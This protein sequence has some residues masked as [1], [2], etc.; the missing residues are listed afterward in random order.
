MASR[1]RR[2]G[3]RLSTNAHNSALLATPS[4]L[5]ESANQADLA[6]QPLPPVNPTGNPSAPVPYRSMYSAAHYTPPIVSA[7]DVLSSHPALQPPHF[8]AVNNTVAPNPVSALQNQFRHPF[9]IHPSISPLSMG[10]GSG[11]REAGPVA[12]SPPW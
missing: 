1:R 12:G 10:P 8:T 9:P 3:K 6:I 11:T 7:V 5:R 2:N 4:P